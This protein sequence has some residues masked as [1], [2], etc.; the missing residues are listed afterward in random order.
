MIRPG[1]VRL[2]LLLLLLFLANRLLEGVGGSSVLLRSWLDDV[3][4]MPLALGA[5]LWLHRRRIRSAYWTMP[6]L[7]VVFAVVLYAVLFEFVLPLVSQRATGDP[8]DVVAYS[9]GAAL[10]QF[11]LNR[12]G[13]TPSSGEPS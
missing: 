6:V 9:A 12:P 1:P 10:F 2:N 13:S 8:L 4:V 7:Q 3:L 11:A 5:A